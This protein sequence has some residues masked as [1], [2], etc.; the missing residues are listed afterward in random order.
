MSTLILTILF[1]KRPCL[2]LSCIINRHHSFAFLLRSIPVFFKN[3]PFFYFHHFNH[4]STPPILCAFSLSFLV[5]CLRH[6]VT[7]RVLSCMTRFLCLSFMFVLVS[8]SLVVCSFSFF[9]ILLLLP[10]QWFFFFYGRC[11]YRTKG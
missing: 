4:L 10:I 7:V 8:M 1:L 2:L 11:Q 5:S 9:S 6:F 3:K